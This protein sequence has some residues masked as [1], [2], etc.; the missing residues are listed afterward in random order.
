MAPDP[1]HLRAQRFPLHAAVETGD[2][3]RTRALLEGSLRSQINRKYEGSGQTPL[4][5]AASCGD[6]AMIALLLR[7]GAALDEPDCVKQTPLHYSVTNTQA[8]VMEALVTAGA[9]INTRRMKDGWTPL[10]LAAIFGHDTKV[11]HLVHSG[12][13]VLLCD[14]RGLTVMDWVARYCLTSTKA[15]LK[16]AP[17][18]VTEMSGKKYVESENKELDVP[19]EFDEGIN[20]LLVKLEAKRKAKIEEHQKLLEKMERDKQK[21]REK[22]EGKIGSKTEGESDSSSSDLLKAT[23]NILRRQRKNM[24]EI[25]SKDKPEENRPAF[26][27]Q[28]SFKESINAL[29]DAT[30]ELEKMNGFDEDDEV[31]KNP[32]DKKVTNV[33]ADKDQV[34]AAKMQNE[35]VRSDSLCS[36]FLPQ[37][38][39]SLK[40]QTRNDSS[41]TNEDKSQKV[42]SSFKGFRQIKLM[43][44]YQLKAMMWVER[45]RI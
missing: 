24:E 42:K 39:E 13:D 41:D 18:T 3:A 33:I 43:K 44:L 36:N 2:L 27:P 17:R 22:L 14:E 11:Q 15:I 10:F 45:I 26:R 6:Q 4:H 12:A 20:K 34:N 29:F 7:M 37:S 1:R 28:N 21:E 30:S 32:V 40:C 16:K 8:G 25:M 23:E 38:T 35:S 5:L 19:V 31:N 9:E